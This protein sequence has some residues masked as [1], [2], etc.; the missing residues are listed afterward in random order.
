MKQKF[1]NAFLVSQFF[2]SCFNK[3]TNTITKIYYINRKCDV[4]LNK[5]FN[6]IITSRRKN[7]FTDHKCIIDSGKCQYRKYH[8]SYHAFSLDQV[9]NNSASEIE[10]RII[11]DREFSCVK[12]K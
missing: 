1:L 10:R 12:Y 2:I 4:K 5:K 7:S 11:S 9:C 3:N 6:I 8:S